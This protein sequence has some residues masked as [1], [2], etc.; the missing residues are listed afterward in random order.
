MGISLFMLFRYNRFH[1]AVYSGI[2]NEFSGRINKQYN[3]I[4]Y[5][6][7][8]KKTN[9]SLVKANEKLYN[10][11]K[12]DFDMADTSSALA[13]DT[14][15]IDSLT[16]VRRFMYMQAKVVGNSVAAQ[17]NFIQLHRGAD[18]D[19]TGD[20]GVIDINNSVVGTT[21]DVSK[22]FSVVMSLLN[23]QSNVSAKLKKS[24]ET[25]SVVWDGKETNVVMLKDISKVVK[26][27]KGDTVITSGFSEKFPYG[28]MIGTVTDVVNDKS[29]SHYI[30]KVKTSA[31]F[32]NLQYVYVINNLQKDE[33]RELL[34]K[35]KKR[36]E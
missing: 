23:V 11:L 4:E 3:T 14:L 34:N 10:R 29:L 6:F 25:G 16:Q 24:G 12:S 32:Y 30:I 20:L 31:N 8:L 33:A 13:V 35:V 5:Y 27:A 36:N 21:M 9:D 15:R 17:N 2:A 19:V 26:V 22:N 7:Q 1:N 28:L 18:Q